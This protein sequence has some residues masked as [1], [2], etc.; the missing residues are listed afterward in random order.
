MKT[1]IYL[2]SQIESWWQQWDTDKK[3]LI[4]LIDKSSI[5]WFGILSKLFNLI[6]YLNDSFFVLVLDKYF[7]FQE[8]MSGNYTGSKKM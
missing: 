4:K 3:D 6:N 7:N 5:K 8:N 1:Y 2:K